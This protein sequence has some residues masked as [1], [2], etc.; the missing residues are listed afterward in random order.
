MERFLQRTFLVDY[1][2]NSMQVLTPVLK[3]DSIHNVAEMRR[4]AAITKEKVILYPPRIL[5]VHPLLYLCHF[6]SS[7]KC[8]LAGG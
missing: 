1:T 4:Q 2:L 6:P 7:S 3:S 5:R 8:L